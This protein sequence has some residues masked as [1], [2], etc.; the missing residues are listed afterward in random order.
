MIIDKKEV[1]RYLG[2]KGSPEKS[3]L[4]LIDTISKRAHEEIFPKRIVLNLPVKKTC[5]GFLIDGSSTILK[6]K[7]ICETLN[8]CSSVYIFAATLAHDA[9]MLLKNYFSFSE[10][11]GTVCDAVLTA[12]IESFCDE[13]EKEIAQ[14]ETKNGRYVKQRISC[15]YGDFSLEY[16]KVFFD[17]LKITKLIGVKLLDSF[18]MYPN[19]SV[20]ALIAVSDKPLV[21]SRRE[22]NG[23]DGNC[24][25]RRD[26][27][28]KNN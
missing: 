24:N 1:L 22:C 21:A 8:D 10:L 15:G 26:D 7:L 3:L 20:T 5:D 9:E 2:V 17:L 18:M 19:K 4:E 13:I 25:F 16:Q 14:Q 23:C 27:E 11:S 6:G 12:Y 28:R